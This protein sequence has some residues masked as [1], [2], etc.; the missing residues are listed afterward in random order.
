MLASMPGT[1]PDAIVDPWEPAAIAYT[2]GTSGFPKG[3]VHSQHNILLPGAVN[4]AESR[5]PADAPQG[6][7]LPLTILNVIV[8]GPMTAFQDGT[9]CVAIDRIDPVGLAGWVRDEKVAS[10]GAVPTVFYDLLTHPDVQVGDL[11][12]LRNPVVGGSECPEE[13]RTLFRERFGHD[14]AIAYGMTEAPTAVALAEGERAPEPGYCGRAAA[15][16]EVLIHDEQGTGLPAGVVG[17]I[18]VGPA[19]TGPWAGSYT[20]MLGYW[21]QPEASRS[22]LRGGYYHTGD[23]GVLEADGR[24][25]IRGRRSELILR[26]GANVYPA[27]VER[28]LREHPA[29]GVPDRR[30]GQRVAAAVRIGA[31]ESTTSAALHDHCIERLARYKVPDRI[32][33]VE[34]LPRN[35][36]AKVVKR[37]LA[38]L[39]ERDCEER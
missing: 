7:V 15:Q 18:V 2:S 14:V 29:V 13:F 19:K 16:C 21:N 4:A 30:L 8:L 37:E 26:G 32:E 28:V 20:P 34:R 27:E 5:Y 33:I 6:V 11:A 1:A 17:E 3:A 10:F 22:A 9:A 35:A 39:F 12:T 36:M 31:G 38:A 23:V 24:L 25:F